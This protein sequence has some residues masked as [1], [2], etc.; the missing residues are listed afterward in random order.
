MKK[1]LPIFLAVAFFFVSTSILG[2]EA[3]V[4]INRFQNLPAYMPAEV[5]IKYKTSISSGSR[6]DHMQRMGL[7][8]IRTVGE[9]AIERVSLPEGLGVAEAVELFK[10]DPEIEDVQPNGIFRITA[11]PNDPYFVQQRLWALHNTG[12][13]VNGSSGTPGA[14]ISMVNSWDIHTGSGA[15]VVAVIDTGVDYNHPDLDGNIWRDSSSNP[16]RDFVD[17]DNDPMDYNGHGTHVAGTIGARGNN[18]VGVAGVNWNVRIMALRAFNTVGVGT[19]AEIIPA[20]DYARVNGAHL[21]NASWSGSSASEFLRS[22]IE[23]FGNAGGLFVAAAGNDGTDNDAI[24]QYPASWPLSCIIAVAAT[25]QN[26]ALARFSSYGAASVHLAAPGTNIYSTTAPRLQRYYTEFTGA[27]LDGLGWSS[28]GTNNT[29]AV[30]GNRLTDSP[31]GYAPG[32]NSWVMTPALD[33]AGRA[34]CKAGY[35]FGYSIKTG[36]SL[37][38]QGSTDGIQWNNVNTYTGDTGGNLLSTKEDLK[39]FENSLLYLRFHLVAPPDSS[40]GGYV[41]VDNFQIDCSS[42]DYSGT[43]YAYHQGTSMAAPHVTG[44]TALLKA[45][46]PGLTNTQLKQILIETVDAKPDLTGRVASGGRLNAY[47]A[48]SSASLGTPSGL[49]A[50]ASSSSRIDLAWTDASSNESGFKIQRASSSGGPFEVE[51]TVDANVTNYSDITAAS[52]TTY[53]YRVRSRNAVA[54]SLPSNVATA[55]TPAS[56]TGGGDGGG[57]GG[58]C[59]IATAAFGSPLAGEVQ[60]LRD[61]RDRYLLPNTPGRQFVAV[62]YR[63]SPLIADYISCHESIRIAART[64]LIPVVYTVKYPRSA[65]LFF[66][67]GTGVVIIWRQRRFLCCLFSGFLR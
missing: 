3:F 57:G 28:G 52:S 14:D 1:L 53:Y 43:P 11:Q 60:T 62:Y 54:D 16:G 21:I 26:D 19:E 15:V 42:S 67:C 5:L 31:G 58:G 24:P 22:A 64:G 59:F 9:T 63:F 20:I 10:R 41:R 17:S 30:R 46:D 61:F 44:V 66:L 25:D 12:Q 36:D 56:A 2:E 7:C 40:A 13:I 6:R 35:D 38:L 48:L 39:A 47:K 29:W 33:L 27:T 34:G 32:T 18:G 8:R 65:A 23:S 51:W 4:K 49:S 45:V 37:A 50:I 55:T